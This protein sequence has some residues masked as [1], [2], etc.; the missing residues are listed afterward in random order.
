MKKENQ[1][2]LDTS[3]WFLFETDNN[4][5]KESVIGMKDWLDKP[6][7]KHGF[8]KNKGDNFQFE[9]GTPV[10]FW[11]INICNQRVAPE[12]E[13]AEKWANRCAKYGINLVRMHK[14][15]WPNS[16]IVEQED[17]NKLNEKMARRWDYFNKK[18]AENGIYTGWSHIFGRRLTPADREKVLAYEEIMDLD[19]PWDYLNNS[20]TGLV[21]FAPDLQDLNISLTIN[22]LNRVNHYTGKKYA[23]NPALAYIELQNEDDIFW[24]AASEFLAQCPTYQKLLNE[25]FSEW[26]DEKYE[27]Q[28]VL[29][30]A[31]G[32]LLDDDENLIDK[33]IKA[34]IPTEKNDSPGKRVLDNLQFLYDM[35]NE[36]YQ[37]FKKAIRETGYRG[38][39]VGSCWQASG[40]LGHYYNLQADK[41]AGFID[42]HNYYA[43]KTPMLSNPG[44]GLLS[45]GMQQLSDRPFAV[46]EWGELNIWQTESPP[47]IAIYG[48]G[49]QDWDM[50]CIFASNQPGLLKN[51]GHTYDK[52]DRLNQ[53]GQFPVL[54]RMIYREDVQS[55]DVISKRQ[56]TMEQLKQ[57]EICFDEN[58]EQEGNWGD[59]KSFSG[60]VPQEALAAGRVVLSLKDNGEVVPLKQDSLDKFINLN[61]RQ[62]HSSTGQLNWNFKD[63]GYFVLDTPGTQA[64]IGFASDKIHKMSDINLEIESPFAAIYVS[65]L[66]QNKSI[67]EANSL[68]ITTLART[69][70]QDMEINRETG[71]IL[72]QGE[73]RI[74][75]E[76]VKANIAI[77]RQEACEIY[78]L[79]HEGRFI[80]DSD[81]IHVDKT[82]ERI[83]FK[84]DGEKYQTI[85]Y[86][87]KFQ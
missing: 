34:R 40:K 78:I 66:D 25:R 55:G 65:S 14:F 52:G 59:H 26:L 21:N 64:V 71:E 56:V 31:W 84:V 69:A 51:I 22:M 54:A 36:Y 38:E 62:I 18:L 70:N 87:A 46:T 82:K 7:G 81:R 58:V 5:K 32:E 53:V 4:F 17:G 29:E 6:A 11:G 1:K 20:T 44:S 16:G 85:Y 35:Q 72:K 2:L 15:T 48:L 43:S 83:Q 33:S 75:I 73:G 50:S 39:I 41:K 57:G 47:L 61:C 77:K 10:K 67:R 68:L 63:K 74:V 60:V 3:D 12:K 37:K 79:D 9:D 80:S 27:S 76:P 13:A 19:L 42:R 24:G 23:E 45:T 30:K 8:L 86:L 49:L 28:K